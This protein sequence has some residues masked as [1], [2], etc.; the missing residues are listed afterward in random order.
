MG[1]DQEKAMTDLRVQGP[2]PKDCGLESWLNFKYHLTTTPVS[3]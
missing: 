2:H 1:F 3:I